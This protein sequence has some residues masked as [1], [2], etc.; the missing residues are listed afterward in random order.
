MALAFPPHAI[1]SILEIANNLAASAGT[2]N[3]QTG[4][5][6]ASS[7]SNITSAASLVR[8]ND[9]LTPNWM[10]ELKMSQARN[11]NSLAFKSILDQPV[12]NIDRL[13]ALS[14]GGIPMEH[15]PIVWQILLN[16]LPPE[17]KLHGRILSDKRNQ[18][19]QLVQKFYQSEMSP[20][21]KTLLNQ[22]KLDVP[23]T[24]PKG[25]SQTPLFKSTILHLVLERILYVWSKTNPLI[26]YF[27]GLNDIPAQF[28]LV[29][30]TQYINIHGNLTDLNCDILDKVEADTFWCLSLLMNNL[31]NRFINFHD[32]I[33]RMAMKLERL[34]KLK[35]ENLSKHLQNE[36]CDFILFSL[37]WMICLLSREFEFRLCNR[38]WDS[39]IAH[40]PNFGYFHIYV[41]AA[42]I[43]TKE[44][45]PVL[46]KR[47][48]SD[49][50]VFLQRLPTDSW[51]IHHID[52][53]LVGAYQI[54]LL[55]IQSAV[56]ESTKKIVQ[57][58]I[59]QNTNSSSSI[60]N[61]NNN[62]D[63]SS[64][65]DNNS[66]NN[67]DQSVPTIIEPI[68][69]NP[70]LLENHMKN[71]YLSFLKSQNNHQLSSSINQV[72]IINN[73]SI[74]AFNNPQQQLAAGFS[75]LNKHFLNNQNN[76]SNSNN[77]SPIDLE[78]IKSKI[79]TEFLPSYLNISQI[80]PE[81]ADE[82]MIKHITLHL[83]VIIGALLFVGVIL[84]VVIICTCLTIISL[85][86]YNSIDVSISL[87]QHRFNIRNIITQIDDIQTL[88]IT[89]NLCLLNQSIENVRLKI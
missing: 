45:V 49:L 13:R 85:E 48:F 8:I 34:V 84:L 67:N 46:Q 36:G 6:D 17:K 70:L 62:N 30:L 41:C 33:N 22:V 82:E 16:Y 5:G 11:N 54:F 58:F 27:Q 77:N 10:S 68:D 19:V 57:F 76:N 55:E 89:I 73:S 71:I 1:Q 72:P 28:L 56:Q 74:A 39:Y 52:H 64:N 3:Q 32:G 86:Y 88:D 80:S 87:D 81:S 7:T 24:M 66:S 23:R 14:F 53:L 43:T 31:K 51:N 50:I 38:L 65:D 79:M 61:N 26:S 78:Q 35:E 4:S 18:Y 40:G 69:K 83:M 21:D 59:S 29:F 12:I 20:D 15:R 9:D 75:L 37:R 44:W 42:L 47:E 63:N 2:S 60:D 25:F